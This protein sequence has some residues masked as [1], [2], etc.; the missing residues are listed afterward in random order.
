MRIFIFPLIGVLLLAW[1]AWATFANRNRM[2]LAPLEMRVAAGILGAIWG[3]AMANLAYAPDATHRIVGF[4]LPV[5]SW[6]NASGL[7]TDQNVL[8]S[9]PCLLLDILIGSLLATRLLRAAWS[10]FQLAR[11]RTRR[12]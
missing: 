6:V 7:W 1:G 2:V 4:P 11:A 12:R 3:W 8:A 9:V 10:R 5:M